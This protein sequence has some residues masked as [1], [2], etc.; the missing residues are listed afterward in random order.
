MV[1]MTDSRCSRRRFLAIAGGIGLATV[2]G[3]SRGQ[4]QLVEL[5]PGY[6][7]FTGY[8]TGVDG[9]GDFACLDDLVRRD[10]GFDVDAEYQANVRAA[11]EVGLAGA[12]HLWTWENWMVIEAVRGLPPTCYS[13]VLLDAD[14]RPEPRGNLVVATDPRMLLGGFGTTTALSRLAAEHDIS[15]SLVVD[16]F[17]WDH[18]LRALI[19]M[20]APG[21]WNAVQLL[22]GYEAWMEV[23]TMRG[24]NIAWN[25]LWRNLV[26]Q[27]GYAPTPATAL[28]EDQLFMFW[29]GALAL[30]RFMTIEG[31]MSLLR[32]LETAESQWKSAGMTGS[33]ADYMRDIGADQWLSN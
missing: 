4:C 17:G 7:G 18:G 29:T 19:G 14:T 11:A 31:Q 9:I 5:Y 26:A 23:P 20:A 25:P 12:P 2:P 22:E 8:V 32:S 16:T 15:R 13:C 28:P 1:T 33:F 27:G 6:P 3:R 30:M 21:H 10:P 24:S